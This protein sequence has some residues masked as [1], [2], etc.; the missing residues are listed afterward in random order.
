MATSSKQQWL[1]AVVKLLTWIFLSLCVSQQPVEPDRNECKMFYPHRPLAVSL[2]SSDLC[3]HIHSSRLPLMPH[4]FFSSLHWTKSLHDASS[5]PTLLPILPYLQLD[6]SPHLPYF[7]IL[8]LFSLFISYPVIESLRRAA[9]YRLLQIHA[10][11]CWEVTGRVGSL[12]PLT[13]VF[14][15]YSPVLCQLNV[16][17]CP[18]LFEAELGCRNTSCCISAVSSFNDRIVCLTKK[19]FPL[20]DH[21]RHWHLNALSPLLFCIL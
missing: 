12:F 1:H 17:R 20:Q 4:S 16:F 14:C 8:L 13:S 3:F 7:T 18:T 11:C 6:L 5:H 21:D 2:P 15:F 10:M 19:E 9:L